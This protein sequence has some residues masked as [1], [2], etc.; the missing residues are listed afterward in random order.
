V[1]PAVVRHLLEATILVPQP[2]T[3]LN[4]QLISVANSKNLVSK[5]SW[6]PGSAMDIGLFQHD[7]GGRASEREKGKTPRKMKRQY[8]FIRGMAFLFTF[9]GCRIVAYI[10][11]VG[12]LTRKIRY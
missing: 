11:S 3:Y 5:Y 4:L 10:R 7:R 12:L 2:T 1:G 8:H 9:F 6:F